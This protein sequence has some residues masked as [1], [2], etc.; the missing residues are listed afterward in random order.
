[1]SSNFRS[2]AFRYGSALGVGVAALAIRLLAQPVLGSRAPFITSYLAVVAAAWFFGTGP[3]IVVALMGAISAAYFFLGPG[4]S[5]AMTN[6]GDVVWFG[7]YLVVVGAMIAALEAL[8]RAKTAA[9]RNTQ[10]A[11][12]RLNALQRAT[13]ERER[14]QEAEAQQ[15]EWY[16]TTLR[17][18]GDAVIATGHK[19]EVVFLNHVAELLTGW[20]SEEAV[21][22]PIGEVFV[23]RNEATGKPGE[24]P[25]DH[26]LRDGR[27][28]GLANHTVLIGRTGRVVPIDDS[29][30]P[31]RDSRGVL[32]GVVLVFRDIAARRDSERALERT[33]A[34]MEQFAYLASHDLQAPLRTIISFGSLLERGYRDGLDGTATEYLNFIIGGARHMQQ[35]VD[36]LLQYCQVGATA[37][38][39]RKVHV[40]HVLQDV[41]AALHQQIR[42]SGADIR[43]DALPVVSADRVKLMQVLQNLI[44]NAIKFRGEQPL[45]IR[46][47]AE[48][49]EGSW[50]FSVQDNGIGFEPERAEQIF[51]M[52]RRLHP[53][54]RY[55]G[56][57]IGLAIT[58]RIIE[59]HNGRIW[60]ESEPGCG[61]TFRFTLPPPSAQESSESAADA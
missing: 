27:V 25:V 10:L 23:I 51:G 5:F 43:Y 34:E 3:A 52:F 19:G 61:A 40:E 12:E 55:S 14:A 46:V 24:N 32:I 58:K 37:I 15:R 9:D 38:S 4:Q 16:E 49:R 6:P 54:E 60:A 53:A 31:I 21:G 2:I 33:A 39:I 26:V 11:I 18:I 57:G 48:Q 41:L 7:F 22:R 56:S 47:S 20:S 30:A 35:L 29:A 50:C 1:M 36:D 42:E 44:G 45:Q 13:A 17:S 8:R 59:S 28:S